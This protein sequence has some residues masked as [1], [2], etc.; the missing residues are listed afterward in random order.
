M[1]QPRL[2]VMPTDFDR[3][4]FDLGSKKPAIAHDPTKGFNV[5]KPRSVSHFSP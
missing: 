2:S 5:S 3:A 1:T 4:V